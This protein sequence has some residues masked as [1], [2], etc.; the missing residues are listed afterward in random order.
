LPVRSGGA[1]P[2]GARPGSTAV[3][4][5]G[6]A[7]MVSGMMASREMVA[8]PAVKSMLQTAS[9]IL[10]YN[11]RDTAFF[12]PDFLLAQPRYAMP[13]T[14]VLGMVALDELRMAEQEAADRVGCY[15]GQG[16][17]YITALCA[18]GV[19]TFEQGLR[20]VQARGEIVDEFASQVRQMVVW[21]VGLDMQTAECLC[22]EA[23][24]QAGP[25]SICE[26]A[27]VYAHDRCWIAGT[28][29]AVLAFRNMNGRQEGV[30][31]S[32]MS[33]TYAP[34]TSLMLPLREKI[35]DACAG[36]LNSLK[37]PKHTVWSGSGPV[38]FRPGCD[39]KEIR[40]DLDDYLSSP[41]LWAPLVEAIR[42]VDGIY[43]FWELGH[44]KGLKGVMRSIDPVLYKRMKNIDL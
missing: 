18:A 44:M 28:E 8:R 17:G 5:S 24:V 33:L 43:D 4:F 2:R 23:A 30:F 27:C 22:A 31:M 12:G 16:T 6:E 10:G 11:V 39:P 37:P 3:V 21:V 19:L 29:K 35:S 42:D 15:S 14:F 38:A 9:A 40:D 32:V 36:I 25:G 34:M 26:V 7:F 41:L 1:P 13:I 20:L